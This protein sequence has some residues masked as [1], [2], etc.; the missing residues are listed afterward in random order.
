[1]SEKQSYEIGADT[2]IRIGEGSITERELKQLSQLNVIVSYM[3][4][5]Y[6]LTNIEF[7]IQRL[8]DIGFEYSI[9]KDVASSVEVE[10]MR[11]FRRTNTERL[12]TGEISETIDKPP[13]SVSRALSRLVD[14][15]QI[16][17]IR[18]GVYASR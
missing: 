13:S 3:A 7:D 18:R 6:E 4:N 10:V 17:R 11:V 8:R 5:N 2:A 14:K 9:L 1:M 16:E 15:G 12:T